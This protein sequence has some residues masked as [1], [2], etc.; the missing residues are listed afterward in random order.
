MPRFALLVLAL[1]P[2]APGCFI[3]LPSVAR[4]P[5]TPVPESADV[6]AIVVRAKRIQHGTAPV[7]EESHTFRRVDLKDGAVGPQLQPYFTHGFPLLGSMH[8][9][10]V[11]I[12]LYRPGY[13]TIILD[14]HEDATRVVWEPALAPEEQAEAVRKL[15]CHARPGFARVPTPSFPPGSSDPRH[16]EVLLFIAS[17]DERVGYGSNARKLRAL[18]AE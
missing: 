5:G 10:Y 3:A 8:S 14:S 11:M 18:A 2:G 17:E 9:E 6:V 16:R 7:P 15:L 13:K 4:V 12:K 1:L